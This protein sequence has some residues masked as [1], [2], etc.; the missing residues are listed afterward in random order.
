MTLTHILAIYFS[1][2]LVCALLAAYHTPYWLFGIPVSFLLTLL[3]GS[4]L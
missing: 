2:G 4:Y 1:L 3:I